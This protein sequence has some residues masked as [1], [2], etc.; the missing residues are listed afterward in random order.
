LDLEEEVQHKV[1]MPVSSKACQRR[2]GDV[3]AVG[4]IMKE[5]DNTQEKKHTHTRKFSFTMCQ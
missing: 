5:E 4:L 2:T 1:D 3:V